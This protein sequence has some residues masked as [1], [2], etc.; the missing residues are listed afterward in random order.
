MSRTW[1]ERIA[2]ARKRGHWDADDARAWTNLETC[3]AGVV[4]LEYGIGV[5]FPNTRYT[6]PCWNDELHFLGNRFGDAMMSRDFDRAEN[7]LDQLEDRALQLKR[8]HLG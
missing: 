1:R 5:L 7:L 3:P 6:T 4:A 2:E 8:E